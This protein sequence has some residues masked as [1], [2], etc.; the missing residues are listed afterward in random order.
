[1]VSLDEILEHYS[2]FI[3]FYPAIKPELLFKKMLSTPDDEIPVFVSD[4]IIVFSRTPEGFSDWLNEPI[5]ISHCID[6]EWGTPLRL[7]NSNG[8][9]VRNLPPASISGRL[10]FSQQ[11]I[12]ASGET[13]F[14]I[15]ICDF[16]SPDSINF[17]CPGYPVNTEFTDSWPAFDQDQ[18]LYFFS[19][20][21]GGHGDVDLYFSILENNLYK[22]VK[23]MGYP[24]NTRWREHDPAI[25][26]DGTILVFAS[27]R[28]GGFGGDDLYFCFRLEDGSWSAPFN[29][30][31]DINTSADENRPVFSQEGKNI[32]FA[33]NTSG[34]LDIF[35][36]SLK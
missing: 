9:W 11:I 14:D 25:S 23:N 26:S 4:S 7:T 35:K 19:N 6:R 24:I 36:I 20:R 2:K 12:K 28:V 34:N 1:M 27:N 3:D 22:S 17:I 16:I 30:G 18:N 29:L 10:A 33:S 31:P 8:S 32:F 15:K 21:P 5:Y 13:N